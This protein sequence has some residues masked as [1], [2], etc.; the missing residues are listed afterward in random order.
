M[1]QGD[2]MQETGWVFDH[3]LTSYNVRL[4]PIS[5]ARE[6]LAE[7]IKM[8]HFGIE[9]GQKTGEFHNLATRLLEYVLRTKE[10]DL[11]KLLTDT[12]V[13][14]QRHAKFYL[15]DNSTNL[16][17]LC[18]F[19]LMQ[20]S[21]SKINI[22]A[23]V[24]QLIS[25]TEGNGGKTN[26]RV[27][28]GSRISELDGNLYECF[29]LELSLHLLQAYLVLDRRS[30]ENLFHDI[31]NDWHLYD[32]ISEEDAIEKLLWYGFA[33]GQEDLL[34]K[35]ILNEDLLQKSDRW[36]IKFY[37]YLKKSLAS[38]KMNVAKI[39]SAVEHFKKKNSYT[40]AEKLWIEQAIHSRIEKWKSQKTAIPAQTVSSNTKEERIVR[41]IARLS[42]YNLPDGLR[43]ED[44]NTRVILNLAVFANE[45]QDKMIKTIRTE[46]LTYRNGTQY[47]VSKKNSQKLREEAKP[48]YIHVLNNKKNNPQG[49]KVKS[50]DLFAWPSTEITG[51]GFETADD[52]SGLSE[53][54]A[55]RKMGYQ[56]TNTTREKRWSVLQAAVPAIGLKKIA[57]TIAG[58]VKL[59]KGQ[60]NGREKFRYAISE[61]EYDLQILKQK[62]Y[63]NEF[64]WP[65]T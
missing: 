8:S 58:N 50:P 23:N 5:D 14:I 48:G 53:I 40:Q 46:A 32:G 54:S 39:D 18:D 49:T 37:L 51:K 59:R 62:Y 13:K 36:G 34:E 11:A 9:R 26:F 25:N 65:K 30:Q 38:Q 63:K 29:N 24:M 52:S 61:W 4:Q 47:F 28:V 22:Y 16:K 56:I 45:K 60:K 43:L 10:A 6:F 2:E 15:T 17:Q 35:K 55:L 64:V 21:H 33:L 20:F 41:E 57:Y 19:I 1:L 27:I 7:L 31:L 12:L 3:L 44:V 42:P